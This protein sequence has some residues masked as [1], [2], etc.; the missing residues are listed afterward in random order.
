[1]LLEHHLGH[2]LLESSA[3]RNLVVLAMSVPPTTS[4]KP[5]EGFAHFNIQGLRVFQKDCKRAQGERLVYC[6]HK[7]AKTVHAAIV[8]GLRTKTLI[9]IVLPF[10]GPDFAQP[11]SAD[12]TFTL[13]TAFFRKHGLPTE[14]F[15]VVTPIRLSE[16]W[17]LLFY[18]NEAL[19]TNE[20]LR[21]VYPRVPRPVRPGKNSG[22]DPNRRSPFSVSS[23]SSSA[24]A[25]I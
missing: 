12:E 18:D 8:K 13:M 7:Y 9:E 3:S 10:T 6:L 21:C 23:V 16:H 24:V 1:M 17:K 14:T 4:L 15:F 22:S 25:S 5:R 19:D 20:L 11:L 2:A